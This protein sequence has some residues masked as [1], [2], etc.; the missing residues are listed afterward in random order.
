MQD[1]RLVIPHLERNPQEKPKDCSD[2]ISHLD[3]ACERRDLRDPSTPFALQT[4]LG[5]T[6]PSVMLNLRACPLCPW[7]RDA[8]RVFW[9]FSIQK[10]NQK[11]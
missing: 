1:D 7:V 8:K 4:L 5:M 11:D 3:R 6:K 2:E 10:K 9:V